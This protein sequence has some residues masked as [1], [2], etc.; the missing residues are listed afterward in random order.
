[1][2]SRR[3]FEIE[4]SLFRDCEKYIENRSTPKDE[5][6]EACV[7]AFGAVQEYRKILQEK[8]MIDNTRVGKKNA[9]DNSTDGNSELD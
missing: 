9:K 8:E 4:K 5:A 3:A 2:N 6:M 7:K 1:M